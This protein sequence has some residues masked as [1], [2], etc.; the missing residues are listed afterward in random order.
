[1]RIILG[2]ISPRRKEILSY[3]SLPFEQASPDYD[4]E[5]IPYTGNPTDYVCQLS[6]G[7]ADS[8]AHRFPDDI[9]ITAD[10]IV[11]MNGKIYGKPRN[12]QEG[13]QALSEL[14]GNWHSVFTGVTVRKGPQEYSGA[15]ETKVLFNQLTP[16]QIKWYHQQLHC[17]DK[18]G[19]YAIQ[20]GGGIVIKKIDGCYYNVMGLPMNTLR[21]LLGQVGIDLWHYL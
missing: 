5:S 11:L 1:M 6:K 13:F 4:E 14:S 2:S 20:Q 19:G 12:K 17:E 10:T 8:L 3:F 21:E 18:A 16:E 9:I 7:K 15:E